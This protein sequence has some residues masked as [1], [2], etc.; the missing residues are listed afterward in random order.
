MAEA[1]GHWV[2]AAEAV[3]SVQFWG[4]N[5]GGECLRRAPHVL[6]EALAEPRER[7]EGCANRRSSD[8]RATLLPPPGIRRSHPSR[9]VILFDPDACSR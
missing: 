5:H 6:M 8:P 2:T 7:T 3:T 4:H 9:L 1:K